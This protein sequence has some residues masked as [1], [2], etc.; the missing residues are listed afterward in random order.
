MDLKDSFR[1]TYHRGILKDNHDNYDY[2]F[3]RIARK[4]SVLTFKTKFLNPQYKPF[5]WE[6]PFKELVYTSPEE[7]VIP[8]YRYMLTDL[9]V[10]E[11]GIEEFTQRVVDGIKAY[12]RETLPGINC[13]MLHSGGYDSRILSC[14]MR[15]L[16]LDE[17]L[18]FNIHFRCHQP[19][20]PMFLEIMKR[21]GW[22]KSF[23]SVYP[24][25][26]DNYYNIGLKENTLNGWQ[27]YNQS[28]NFWS[29]ITDNEKEYTLMTGLSGELFKYIA[30]HGKE[31]YPA[32]CGNDNLNILAQYNPDEGQWDTLYMKKF[33]D[34]VMPLYSYTYLNEALRVNPKWCKFNGETDEV[35]IET[36]RRFRYNC[37]DIPYGRHSYSWSLD[38]DFFKSVYNEFY[39]SKFYKQFGKWIKR[40][41]FKNLYKWDAKMWGFMTVY[42]KLYESS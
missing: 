3:V 29:D 34:L 6:T 22:D 19:E 10:T 14:C 13:L 39:A 11:L 26:K 28:M 16:W 32:R 30:L 5:Y 12:L 40:P 20:E 27:N 1:N 2:D 36:T 17:G 24:G 41:N 37:T 7:R 23:Y 9:P 33:N 38:N 42:D 21:Q 31:K 25:Q 8:Q 18:R 15:D 35:R 4:Q